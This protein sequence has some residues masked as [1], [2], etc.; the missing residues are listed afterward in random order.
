MKTERWAIGLIIL[1]TL[2]TSSAVV[3]QGEHQLT[4]S[5]HGN[6]PEVQ[7]GLHQPPRCRHVLPCDRHPGWCAAIDRAAARRRAHAIA[8]AGHVAGALGAVPHDPAHRLGPPAPVADRPILPHPGRKKI[9]PVRRPIHGLDVGGGFI[10]GVEDTSAGSVRVL[11]THRT[12]HC[13]LR[14][15]ANSRDAPHALSRT[16]RGRGSGDHHTAPAHLSPEN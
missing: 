16:K 5:T 8:G 10:A 11:R 9:F 6:V 1:V 13:R 4:V 3:G 14:S 15:R 7:R 2:L 12:R